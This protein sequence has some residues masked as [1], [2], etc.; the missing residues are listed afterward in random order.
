M[1]HFSENPRTN[2]IPKVQ[3]IIVKDTRQKEKSPK[4][5][6]FKKEEGLRR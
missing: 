5:L 6:N 3:K 4:N 2:N 1:D